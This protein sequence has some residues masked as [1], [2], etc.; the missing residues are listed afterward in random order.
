[1]RIR[2]DPDFSYDHSIIYLAETQDLCPLPC[3]YPGYRGHLTQGCRLARRLKVEQVRGEPGTAARV[4]GRPFRCKQAV[5]TS[6]QPKTHIVA[7]NLPFNRGQAQ[8][9]PRL[10]AKCLPSLPK[11][12]LVRLAIQVQLVTQKACK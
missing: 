11:S 5:V 4:S 3:P 2:P 7:P 10:S 1:M 12:R 8:Q 9:M 6:D